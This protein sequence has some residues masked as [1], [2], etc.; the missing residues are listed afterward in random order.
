M[1]DRRTAAPLGEP[2]GTGFDQLP[3]RPVAVTIVLFVVVVTGAAVVRPRVPRDHADRARLAHRRRRPGRG[4][5]A[6]CTPSRCSHSSSGSVAIAA[7]IG[8]EVDRRWRV[9]RRGR[10]RRRLGTRRRSV[11][12]RCGPARCAAAATWVMSM[13]AVSVGRESAIIETAGAAGAVSARRLRRQGRR[14]GGRRASRLRS[15]R[16]TTHPSRRCSTSRST[17]AC[18]AAGGRCM[19]TMAGAF[20]GQLATVLAVRR[21]PDLPA[22][23]RARAGRSSC[24]RWW[25][26]CRRCWRPA[27]SSQLRVRLNGRV[28]RRPLRRAPGMVVVGLQRSWPGSRWRCSRSPPATGW[29]GCGRARPEATVTLALALLDRQAGRHD[30]DA[31]LGRARW[32]AQPVDG[33]SP[34]GSG[35]SRCWAPRE[36]GMSVDHP[37]DAMVA[38]MAIGVAVGLRSPLRRDRADPRDARRLH[39]GPGDRAGRRA[40]RW[41]STVGST[42]SIDRFGAARARRRVRRGRL[43]P[44]AGRR[45]PSAEADGDLGED[46]ALF[47]AERRRRRRPPRGPPRTAPAAARGC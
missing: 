44:R 28:D 3:R 39:A 11:A 22:G 37:W 17:S 31:R 6:R 24:R 47:G 10:G 5:A 41:S 23:A 45:R 43:T 33:A 1:T 13:G 34:A 40:S 18:A 46:R 15:P 2:L 35:C 21:A 8:L 12:S 16:R 30:G 26:W 19:F 32:C 20:G 29:R 38:C 14:D 7:V 25:R 27:C 36:L 4:G 9:V 42:L